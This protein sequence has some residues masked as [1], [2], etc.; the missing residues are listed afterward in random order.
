MLLPPDLR[1]W[2]PAEDMVHFVIE[3]VAGMKLPTLKINQRGC[4]SEQYPPKM[5]LQLL[6]C[7][8]AN[9]ISPSRRIERATYRDVAV[10]FLTADTHPDH[11]TI[12][13]F[14]RENFEAVGQSF[15][16]ERFVG[17]FQLQRIGLPPQQLPKTLMIALRRED[18]LTRLGLVIEEADLHFLEA[19][20]TPGF[21]PGKGWRFPT[22]A[23]PRC[24]RRA[25]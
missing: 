7:C 16:E 5:M 21:R 12:C 10:R 15:L 18:M 9:G 24:C 25:A 4:G 8:Y 23:W 22:P 2:V 1:E 3:A 19:L 11:D 14:R 20:V 17:P 13:T 6:V